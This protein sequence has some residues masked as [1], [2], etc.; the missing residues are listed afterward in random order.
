MSWIGNSVES[1]TSRLN[2]LEQEKEVE[3]IL[4]QLA[5]LIDT[6]ESLLIT[7]HN[8]KAIKILTEIDNTVRVIKSKLQ[9]LYGAITAYQFKLQKIESKSNVVT[10][11]G[12]EGSQT[13]LAQMRYSVHA[14][15]GFRIKL[16]EEIDA[17]AS[18]IVNDESLSI[19]VAAMKKL[20]NAFSEAFIM[21]ERAIDSLQK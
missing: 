18:L 9:I 8:E 6:E 17:L 11:T 7:T 10:Q 21:E 4:D 19:H 5:G 20:F 16:K 12:A 1:S 14:M 15:D 2:I 3:Q 13:A